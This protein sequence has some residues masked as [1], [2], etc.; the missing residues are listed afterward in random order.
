[1]V[2]ETTTAE[3]DFVSEASG[4]DASDLGS[5]AASLWLEQKA[6]RLNSWELRFHPVS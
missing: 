2:V 4:F 5:A 6:R 3:D 1:M